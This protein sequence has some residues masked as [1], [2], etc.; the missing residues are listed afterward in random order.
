MSE[1]TPR[2]EPDP[3]GRA[4]NGWTK[5]P[6]WAARLWLTSTKAK[7]PVVSAV[8]RAV[9]PEDGPPTAAVPPSL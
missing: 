3:E 1:R 8:T 4:Y 6:S 7:Y 2:P 9:A 5:Y